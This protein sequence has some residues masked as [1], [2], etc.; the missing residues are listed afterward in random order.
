MPEGTSSSLHPRS[1]A[2]AAA[3]AGLVLPCA[4]QTPLS[5]SG[6]TIDPSNSGDCKSLGDLDL[7]GKSDPII[8]GSSLCWYESGAGFAKH[9]IRSQTIHK[10]FTTDSQA[11]DLDNDG[12]IDIVLG[13]GGGQDNILWFENPLRN[14]LG[15]GGGNPRIGANWIVHTIGTHGDT[16]HD[17]EVAD[18][19]NDGVREVLTSGHGF[20]RL[21]KRSGP[22]WVSANLSSLAGSGVFVGDIDRDGKRDIATISAWLKNPGDIIN[23]AWV[24][25]PISTSLD[26]DECLLADVNTDGRLD[27]VTF[28]AHGLSTI[29]WFEQPV[30]PTTS[31]WTRRTVDILAGAHHPEAVDFNED[32]RTDILA[33]LEF[34]PVAVYVNLDGSPPTFQKVLVA[35]TGG[36]NARSGDIDGDRLP[37]VLACDYIGNPPVRVYINQYCYA[38]CDAMSLPTVLSVNDFVCFITSFALS[39]PYSNCDGS[40]AAPTHNILDFLCFLSRFSAGCS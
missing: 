34:G 35:L 15:G 21:W 5:F 37:D 17:I 26:G 7:D 12:D 25:H 1:S 8:G 30:D 29:W 28:D 19:D 3:I 18:F 13:D 6:T 14:G 39:T 36:H 16:V 40:Q 32:G 22:G 9:I 4:A 31:A 11:A 20:T 10:E 33:G 23:G 38:N 24:R 2:L 27:L